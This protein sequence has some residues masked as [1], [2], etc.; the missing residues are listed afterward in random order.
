MTVP[1]DARQYHDELQEELAAEYQAEVQAIEQET[2]D[3][4][5]TISS[6]N[7]HVKRASI[8]SRLFKN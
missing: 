6:R 5:A 8:L 7:D 4:V 1:T 3:L 2:A